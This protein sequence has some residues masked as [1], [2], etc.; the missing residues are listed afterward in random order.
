MLYFICKLKIKIL[1]MDIKELSRQRK[2]I[3]I[4]KSAILKIEC[5]EIPEIRSNEIKPG[6]NIEK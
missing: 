5:L 6:S 1:N 4:E 2:D 3:F